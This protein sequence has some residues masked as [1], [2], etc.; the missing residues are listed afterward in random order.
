[1]GDNHLLCRA[2]LIALFTGEIGVPNVVG[3][4]SFGAVLGALD[5]QPEIS[6]VVLDMDLPGMQGLNGPRKLR[7]LYPRLRIALLST[8]HD[9]ADVFGA[10]SAGLHG[11]IPKDLAAA[12]LTAALRTVH[13]GQIYVPVLISAGAATAR[14]PMRRGHLL[15][16]RQQEVL[17]LLALGRSN[18]EIGRTLGITEGTVKVHISA[19]FRQLGVR[20][21]VSAASVFQ[22]IGLTARLDE[23][24]LPGLPFGERRV[25]SH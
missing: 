25:M 22:A 8:K 1:M 15:T 3:V 4:E 19:A 9:R 10:L 18:K 23:P 16:D 20:N 2:G 5:R 12:D 21:R 13:A 14:D 11:F 6:L 7:A 17:G 24:F